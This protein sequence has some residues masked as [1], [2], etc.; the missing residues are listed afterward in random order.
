MARLHAMNAATWRHD[1]FARAAFDAAEV[2]QV[3]A[4]LTAV[5]EGI[6]YAPPVQVLMRQL[7]LAK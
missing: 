5:A 6:I 2:D 1:A 7:V 4:Q 3:I